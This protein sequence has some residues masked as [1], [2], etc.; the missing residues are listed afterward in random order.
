MHIKINKE[1][2][3]KKTLVCIGNKTFLFHL[4]L[5]IT[6]LFIINIYLQKV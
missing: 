2:V 5:M 6:K 3:H 4:G 1:E